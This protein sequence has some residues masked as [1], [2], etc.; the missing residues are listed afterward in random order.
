MTNPGSEGYP[1]DPFDPNYL[2]DLPPPELSEALFDEVSRATSTLQGLEREHVE[3]VVMGTCRILSEEEQIEKEERV[4][5]VQSLLRTFGDTWRSTLAEL[6]APEVN[7]VEDFSLGATDRSLE[8]IE[9]LQM[10]ITKGVQDKDKPVTDWTE[11]STKYALQC[12]CTEQRS[13]G[14]S[15]GDYIR[16]TAVEAIHFPG[17]RGVVLLQNTLAGDEDSYSL[18]VEAIQEAVQDE[19]LGLGEAKEAADLILELLEEA[20]PEEQ[21]TLS[22]L[23]IDVLAC[24]RGW[25]GKIFRNATADYAILTARLAVTLRD[26]HS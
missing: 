4:E 9:R 16:E 17:Y 8:K 20:G 25:N 24:L 15:Y 7:T 18:G 19:S 1:Q 2:K 21:T 6:L 26:L 3:S 22:D 5:H 11:G 23:A 14:V 10:D 12:I 13:I